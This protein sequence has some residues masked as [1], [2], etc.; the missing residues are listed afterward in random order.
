MTNLPS[1]E[2]EDYMSD[3][4]LQYEAKQPKLIEN[5]STT[6]IIANLPQVPESK[7]EKLTS[8]LKKLTG[9][10]G[11]LSTDTPPLMPMNGDKTHGFAFITFVS[12]AD[13]AKCVEAINSYQFDKSHKLSV[14]GYDDVCGLR[15]VPEKYVEKT[16]RPYVPQADVG[17]WL[18]DPGQRDAFCIRQGHET[19]V[20][21]A[22]GL[23]DPVI[24][25]DG[26]REKAAGIQ[27]CKDRME[28]S[29][30]GSFM[31]TII[32]QKGVI[33]WGG[34]KYEKLGRFAHADVDHVSFSPNEGYIMT[35]SNKPDAVDAVKIH[36][37]KT[38]KMIRAF[39]LYPSD[40][41]REE[42]EERGEVNPPQ[43]SWSYN[44]EYI[45]RMGEDL[46]TIYELPSM[47]LL[48]KKSL[49]ADGIKE[50]QWSP[51]ANTLAY[52]SPEK[53]NSPAQVNLVA[54][55][56]RKLLRS[57]NLFQ[58]NSVL[59]SW[60][61]EGRFLGCKVLRHTKSKKTVYNNFELF[62][63]MEEGVPVEM[64]DVKD[65]V[66]NFRWEPGG[67]R[68]AMVHA[69]NAGATRMNVSFY[70]MD[71]T[72][73]AD[74]AG[75]KKKG[76]KLTEGQILPELNLVTTLVDRQCSSLF[77]SP[78]GGVIVLASL[79]DSSSGSLEFYDVNQ[80]ITLAMREHYRATDVNW[81][82]SGRMVSTSVCQPLNGAYFKF[83]MDNGYMLWS[84]QG[85]QL[86]V[87]AYENFYQFKWR[88][89]K[90]VL[91]KE[92][93]KDVET[94]IKKYE[95]E[96]DRADKE[97]AKALYLE[98]TKGKRLQRKTFRDRV[99]DLRA[100]YKSQKQQRIAMNGGYDSDDDSNFT[101]TVVKMTEI[102]DTKETVI[103][104]FP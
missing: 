91:S 42:D 82:P 63:V 85:K 13:A 61:D 24:D 89:R 64:L 4:E 78:A 57:K 101:T 20:H 55:P 93:V 98:E 37:I 68:F 11:T 45:A 10:V 67:S 103:D 95:R 9:K 32:K 53:G 25:Y 18:R 40:K 46:I 48:E 77:W 12:S 7:V 54:I 99:A 83:Q 56:S 22:D 26:S 90:V 8:V 6:V 72:V 43:F 28:W 2:Y 102:I 50:F 3:G 17:A 44:D 87:A 65:A 15:D 104:E 30:K 81:D 97:R 38:G 79:G 84:F 23:R 49:L 73:K 47:K 19:E 92:A 74:E 62:R 51:G 16:A 33:L 1:D 39:K 100:V 31:A 34:E 60:Q 36:D 27:W 96:F 86:F 59:M 69:E 52:W 5:F 35:V 14:H 75:T 76:K 41:F 71:K 58:V 29:P 94:N 70:D 88:P 66:F 80:T 21:W